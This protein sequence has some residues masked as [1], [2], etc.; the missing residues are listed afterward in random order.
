MFS[1]RSDAANVLC[2]LTGLS[3]RTLQAHE[4]GD[5]VPTPDTLAI[6]ARIYATTV[7]YL[8]YGAERGKKKDSGFNQLTEKAETGS[9]HNETIRHIVVLTATQIAK[10][11][12]AVHR[13]PDMHKNTMP[14][15][16]EFGDMIGKRAFIYQVPPNDMSMVGP[17]S[18]YQIRPGSYLIIDP[19]IPLEPGNV[20]LINWTSAPNLLVRLFQS[21]LPYSAGKPFILSA[22]NPNFAELHVSKKS[23][24]KL[25]NAAW[26]ILFAWCTL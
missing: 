15:P 2:P 18:E 19:D 23:D 7:E 9:S 17:N 8:L 13:R 21:A 20:A 3:T 5:R 11:P 26:R 14:I 6:Y 16:S 25:C 24:R 4:R 22:A 12:F 1:T 10:N